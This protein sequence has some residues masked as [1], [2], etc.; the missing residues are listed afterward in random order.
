MCE[1]APIHGPPTQEEWNLVVGNK[2]RT[3]RIE[4]KLDPD[5]WIVAYEPHWTPNSLVAHSR[6]TN[7]DTLQVDWTEIARL[8]RLEGEQRPWAGMAI[9]A[10]I[11]TAGVIT[12]TLICLSRSEPPD[13]GLGCMAL[14]LISSAFIIP[15]SAAIGASVT[16]PRWIPTFC[17][18]ADGA[19]K[20]GGE[21]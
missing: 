13:T 9:G 12:G 4:R 6:P 10:T 3:I 19:S 15:L 18:G 17:S 16:S 11:G 2:T 21:E 20:T 5:K 14:G 7:F 8:E 1:E